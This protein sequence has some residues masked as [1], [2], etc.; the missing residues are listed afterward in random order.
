MSPVTLKLTDALEIEVIGV[1]DVNLLQNVDIPKS[2][3][4]DFWFKSKVRVRK[5]EK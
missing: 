3:H 2:K 1:F 4:L 5:K